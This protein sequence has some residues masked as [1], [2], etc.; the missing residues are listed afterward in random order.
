MTVT[1]NKNLKVELMQ[2]V[3]AVIHKNLDLGYG[4]LAG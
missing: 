1:D 3:K 4:D 2:K